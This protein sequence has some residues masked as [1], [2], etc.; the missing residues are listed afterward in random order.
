MAMKKSRHAMHL[1]ALQLLCL[2]KL[3]QMSK[4]CLQLVLSKSAGCHTLLTEHQTDSAK[5]LNMQKSEQTSEG[6]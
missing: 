4:Y 6:R 5:V 1:K 2:A 3:Q